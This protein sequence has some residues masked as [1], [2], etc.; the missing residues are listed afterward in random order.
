MEE[1]EINYSILPRTRLSEVNELL[2]GHFFPHEP[3]GVALGACP[4]TDVRPWLAKVTKPIVDQ[5][6]RK[7]NYSETLL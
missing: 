6:V 4:E 1:S 2:L 3:L 5:K 7:H